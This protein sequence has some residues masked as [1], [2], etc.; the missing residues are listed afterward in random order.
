[1]AVPARATAPALPAATAAVS[2]EMS[3]VCA[4]ISALVIPSAPMESR[5][6]RLLPGLVKQMIASDPDI[7][8]MEAAYPGL[9][10]AMVSAWRPIMIKASREVM[11][12]YR[13]DMAALYCR[14]FSLPELREIEVFLGSPAFQALQS[15]AYQNLTLERT[16][17]DALND[18][19][20]S[21][22]SIQG[23]LAETGRKASRELS[24]EHQ[25]QI[26]RFMQSPLGRKMA[27]M[28]KEK[29]A[30]DAKW[31]NYLPAWAEQEIATVTIDAMIAH[32]AKTDPKMA[33]QMRGAMSGESSPAKRN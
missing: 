21:A 15:S 16:T 9:G 11:P 1:M 4:R 12:L 13:E 19:D 14:N 2:P 8:E 28:S 7:G 32:I 33:Q 17:G 25:R 22:A 29:L 30:I 26:T 20:V 10:D 18:K 5:I 6:D 3:A 24:P 23:D 31:A 27:A